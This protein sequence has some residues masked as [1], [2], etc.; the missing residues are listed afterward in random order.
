MAR[1]QN[2]FLTLNTLRS[3]SNLIRK[4][5]LA[6]SLFGL[7]LR[8]YSTVP[9]CVIVGQYPIGIYGNNNGIH[10]Y[11]MDVTNSATHLAV[12][13]KCEDNQICNVSPPA[14]IIQMIDLTSNAPIWSYFT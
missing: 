14:A 4:L 7:I 9:P 11:T 1:K 12:G 10:F 13:G 8:T 5:V 3:Y 6:L 2:S